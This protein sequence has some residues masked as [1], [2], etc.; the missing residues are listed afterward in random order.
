MT[1]IYKIRTT[2]WKYLSSHVPM[3][4]VRR[5]P[6]LPWDR[7][8]LS[9]NKELTINDI[10]NLIMP[11]AGGR[12]NWSDISIYINIEEVRQHPN[13]TWNR[14]GLSFNETLTVDDVD[15]LILPNADREWDWMNISRS[16]NI[17]EV[18]EYPDKP[19]DRED[20]S[21]NKNI[22]MYIVDD[23][24][25]PNAVGRWHY[26]YLSEHLHIYDIMLYSNRPWNN[27][28]LMSNKTIDIGI[29]TWK[30]VFK[31]P[32]KWKWCWYEVSKNIRIEDVH[33][34][35]N[36]PWEYG[37]R[38][39]SCNNNLTVNDIKK[40]GLDKPWSWSTLTHNIN[41]EDI[42]RNPQLPWELCWLCHNKRVTLR[43][44]DLISIKRYDIMRRNIYP[45]TIDRYKNKPLSDVICIVIH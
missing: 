43:D 18:I 30:G 16:I 38:G 2:D 42:R 45:M 26:A 44:L 24:D 6:N 4:D 5:N 25:M 29:L 40:I 15:N 11:N 41:I 28:N 33:K 1:N 12:W 14:F 13:K 32:T 19:W 31:N 20:L 35:P 22:M 8:G 36:L 10:D 39:M 34:Y 17:D 21:L 37:Y 9:C 3:H 27:G 23:L 7:E